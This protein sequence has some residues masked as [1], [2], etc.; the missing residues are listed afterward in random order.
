MIYNG[1]RAASVYLDVIET[2]LT[3]P[4][5]ILNQKI[6]ESVEA[7]FNNSELNFNVLFAAFISFTILVAFIFF[8]SKNHFYFN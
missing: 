5:K 6:I 4:T 2:I 3:K 8:Y 7:H 1:I